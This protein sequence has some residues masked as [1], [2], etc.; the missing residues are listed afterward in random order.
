MDLKNALRLLNFGTFTGDVDC[1]E[2]NRPE[3]LIAAV[4]FLAIFL[5]ITK[6]PLSRPG[7]N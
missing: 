6:K 3:G 5:I 7:V 4:F 2:I 1:I